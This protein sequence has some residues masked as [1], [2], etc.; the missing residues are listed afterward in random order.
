MPF[1]DVR[2]L[3]AQ[4]F[5]TFQTFLHFPCLVAQLVDCADLADSP[6]LHIK[7]CRVWSGPVVYEVH[8]ITDPDS[9]A[10][11]SD[12]TELSPPLT[13]GEDYGFVGNAAGVIGV[14]YGMCA[15][16]RSV[17]GHRGVRMTFTLLKVQRNI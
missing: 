9:S 6:V 16:V 4:Y 1:N 14:S 11:T 2:L 10:T 8:P 3:G 17:W 13:E 5:T 15:C 7:R 12:C